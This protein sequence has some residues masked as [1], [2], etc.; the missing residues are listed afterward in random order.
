MVDVKARLETAHHIL[1]HILTNDYSAEQS[2]MQ[3]YEDRIRLDLKSKTNLQEIPVKLL[4][5]KVN[6]VIRKNF[7]VSVN[8][9]DRDEVPENIDLSMVPEEVTSLRIVYIGSYDSQPCINPHVKNTSEIGTYKLLEVKRIG[10]D[11]YRFL[12]TVVD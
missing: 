2:G 5:E 10:R 4:E 1:H 11:A 6:A 3:I 7:P 9:Y 12:G 8:I